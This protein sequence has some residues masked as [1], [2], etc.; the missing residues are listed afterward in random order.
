MA[1]IPS[2]SRKTTL[3]PVAS[4]GPFTVGFPLF[5]ATGADLAVTL[6][7]VAKVVTTH[8]TIS[9]GTPETGFYGAATTWPNATISFLT[10]ITGELIIKG[11]RAPRRTA[12]YNEGAG[13]PARD[14]NADLNI[15]TAVDQELARDQTD[16]QSDFAGLSAEFDELEEEFE[17]INDQIQAGIDAAA[18]AV[19]ARDDIQ[20]LYLGAK[21]G[22][23]ALDNAGN[24]LQAGAWFTLT[25][26]VGP[27]APG[28]YVWTG[29]GWASISVAPESLPRGGS[30]IVDATMASTGVITVPGG[31]TPGY[32]SVKR[33]GVEM[34]IGTPGAGLTDPSCDVSNGTTIV[35]LAGR[36]RAGRDRVT[37]EYRRPFIV[38]TVAAADVAVLPSGGIVETNTQSALQ[39]LDTRVAAL[40]VA[41]DEGSCEL[42]VSASAGAL[43]IALKTLAGN[44]PSVG[45]PLVFPFRD[46]TAS[47]GAINKRSISAAFSGVIS[48]GSTLGAS[49]GVPLSVWVGLIDDGGVMRLGFFN[50]REANGIFTVCN[51]DYV[52]A[53]S[54]GGAGAADN[55][56]TIYSSAGV[57]QKPILLIARLDWDSGLTT[58]GTWTAPTRIRLLGRND[59]YPGML[60]RRRFI[61]N[62]AGSGTASTSYAD[63]NAAALSIT[64]QRPQNAIVVRASAAVSVS[65]VAGI[66]ATH[67]AT[68]M[69]GASTDMGCTRVTRAGSSSGGLDIYASFGMEFVH[70]PGATTAQTYKLV[71]KSNNA[72]ATAFTGPFTLV[73][74]EVES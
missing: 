63:V 47:S 51:F 3:N 53:T 46:Q 57:S 62:G 12:Q 21:T 30:V 35:F 64:P 8:W 1:P 19:S 37:W 7:G 26:T 10:P 18:V 74:E 44:D 29:S 56:A 33:N 25:V 52:D 36:L 58:A 68:I 72:G 71:H 9:P 49:N 22:F 13:V 41:A 11:K 27:N 66:N 24:P 20:K 31:Y 61:N 23:P 50:A 2:S 42:A 43:T 28:P 14:Q 38:G 45:T 40:A 16:I 69:L 55:A 5:D 54:E 39:G 34:H 48:S 59:V 65:L 17:S 15:L 73:L 70:Y 32:V 67:T 6:A 4:T 60:R